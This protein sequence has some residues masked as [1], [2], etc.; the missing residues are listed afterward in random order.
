MNN[1]SY[2]TSILVNIINN[3][4]ETD[5]TEYRDKTLLKYQKKYMNWK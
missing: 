1:F 2:D 5:N 4:N 3:I